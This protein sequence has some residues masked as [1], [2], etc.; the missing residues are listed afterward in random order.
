MT[1]GASIAGRHHTIQLL[2]VAVFLACS[3]SA[4]QTSVPQDQAIADERLEDLA[5]PVEAATAT[6]DQAQ[7]LDLVPCV[8]GGFCT[9][10]DES[11]CLLGLILWGADRPMSRRESENRQWRRGV[12]L[13]ADSRPAG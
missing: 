9:R 11:E 10:K 13:D 12:L 1:R 7:M 8:P 4:E 3:E 6:P 2:L 5:A